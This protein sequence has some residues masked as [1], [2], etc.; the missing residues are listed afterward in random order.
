[1]EPSSSEM[2]AKLCRCGGLIRFLT[3]A[4]TVILWRRNKFFNQAILALE[5]ERHHHYWKKGLVKQIGMKG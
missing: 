5:M 4:L 1:V 3:S 2:R